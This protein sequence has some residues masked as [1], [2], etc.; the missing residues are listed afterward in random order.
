[1][2]L[3][4]GNTS[5]VE[6]GVGKLDLVKCIFLTEWSSQEAKNHVQPPDPNSL[7]YY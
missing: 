2:F 4:S 5:I 1:M 6:S 7:C 3:S